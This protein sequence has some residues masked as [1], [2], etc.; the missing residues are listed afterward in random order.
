MVIVTESPL[1]PGMIFEKLRKED[2][3]SVIFHFAVVKSRAGDRHTSGIRFERDGDM[4]SELSGIEADLKSRWNITDV[5]I[6]RRTGVL[7]I[8]DFISLVAVS[9]PASSDAFEACRYGLERIRK[10]KSVKKTE[11]YTE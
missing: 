8:G 2:A 10:M 6:V 9:S 7:Q 5:L 3:G 11:M 4:E 1:E